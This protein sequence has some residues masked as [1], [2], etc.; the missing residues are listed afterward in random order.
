MSINSRSGWERLLNGQNINTSLFWLWGIFAIRDSD[1]RE[2]NIRNPVVECSLSA[3][4]YEHLVTTFTRL[5]IACGILYGKGGRNRS[6]QTQPVQTLD[7]W[8]PNQGLNLK[9]KGYITE[10]Y[11]LQH[12]CITEF[13]KICVV[14]IFIKH[15]KPILPLDVQFPAKQCFLPPLKHFWLTEFQTTSYIV[16]KFL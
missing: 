7:S 12:I 2:N 13:M 8:R 9:K 16:S 11:S 15:Y 4:C 1:G 3:F 10:P 6:R 14:S 5:N